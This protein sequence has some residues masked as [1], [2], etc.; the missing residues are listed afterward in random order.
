MHHNASGRG[1]HARYRRD[2]IDGLVRKAT[3]QRDLKA[4]LTTYNQQRTGKIADA[5]MRGATSRSNTGGS[6][7]EQS[8][9]GFSS[10]IVEPSP[11]GQVRPSWAAAKAAA[12]PAAGAAAVGTAADRPKK[13]SRA[14]AGALARRFGGSKHNAARHIQKTQR[15]RAVR[16]GLE[17]MASEQDL[18]ASATAAGIV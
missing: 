14:W 13:G 18:F 15:G 16:R 17:S 1:E 2:V 11:A 10:V 12:G 5:W 7:A 6:L 9:G 4:L 3:S 8:S